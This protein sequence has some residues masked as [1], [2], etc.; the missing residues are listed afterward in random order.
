MKA[1]RFLKSVLILPMLTITPLDAGELFFVGEMTITSFSG[2]GCGPAEKTLYDVELAFRGAPPT[3]GYLRHS[4]NLVGELEKL[5]N[6]RW[7]VKLLF[8]DRT[9]PEILNAELHISAE[10]VRATFREQD[11]QDQKPHCYFREAELLAKR[12]ANGGTPEASWENFVREYQAMEHNMMANRAFHL[13]AHEVAIGFYERALELNPNHH[14]FMANLGVIHYR[15]GNVPDAVQWS[16]R[17]VLAAIP[18]KDYELIGQYNTIVREL[19]NSEP[20]WA[21]EKRQQASHFPPGFNPEAFS[22]ELLA[23]SEQLGAQAEKGRLKRVKSGSRESLEVIRKHLG[24]NHADYWDG[25]DTLGRAFEAAGDHDEAERYYQQALARRQ[26]GLG[27]NHPD[28]IDTMIH[29]ALLYKKQ[30]RHTAAHPFFEAIFAHRKRIYGESHPKALDAMV[31]FA[32]SLYQTEDLEAARSLWEQALELHI[33]VLGEKHPDTLVIYNNLANLYYVLGQ[34]DA[35]EPF[36]LKTLDLCSN[37]Y[38]ESHHE[39]LTSLNNLSFLYRAQGR[40]AKA[41]EILLRYFDISNEISDI[42]QKDRAL[43]MAAIQNMATLYAEMGEFEKAGAIALE[44]MR[45]RKELLG[46]EHPLTIV[47]MS[48]LAHLYDSL[49][50]F[51]KARPL[52]DKAMK[53]L[54]VVL[55][56]RKAFALTIMHNQVAHHWIQQQYDRAEP[57][58]RDIVEF[59]E[60][61]LGVEHP[62]YIAVLNNLGA[63]LQRQ[64]RL[65]ETEQVYKEAVRLENHFYDRILWGTSEI[66]RQGYLGGDSRFNSYYISILLRKGTPG[67]WSELFHYS[68]TRKGLLFR[69]ARRFR[70]LSRLQGHPDIERRVSQLR[71]FERRLSYLVMR[72]PWRGE[73]AEEEQQIPDLRERIDRL[74]AELAR[75]MQQQGYQIGNVDPEEILRGLEGDEILL[76]FLIFERHDLI[77]L[78]FIEETL[79]V[80]V[81]DPAGSPRIR[82]VDLGDVE[83][84]RREIAR[85]RREVASRADPTLALQGELYTRLW[86]PL[87]LYVGQKKTV[88]VVPDGPLHLLPIGALRDEDGKHLFSKHPLILLASVR[89]LIRED[90][91]VE[92]GAPAIFHSP[93][94]G[95]APEI[96]SPTSAGNPH[97]SLMFSP[98]P[99]TREEGR[100]LEELFLRE[101]WNTRIFFGNGADEETLSGLRSPRILHLATHGFFLEAPRTSRSGGHRGGE[102]IGLSDGLFSRKAGSSLDPMVFSGLALAGANRRD[103]GNSGGQGFDGILTGKEVLGLNLSGTELVVLSACD[104]GVGEIHQGEGVYGLHRAFQEAGAK[105]VLFTLWKVNDE[106]T[107][108][109][110]VRFYSLYLEGTSPHEAL[111]LTKEEFLESARWSHP[112][113]WAPFVLVGKD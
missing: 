51:D 3:I 63:N 21:E 72:D 16:K 37:I 29:L 73:A 30:E 9:V 98:L 19:Q 15:L 44:L 87:E 79:L 49:L 14:F 32:E 112:Y 33:D 12:V 8:H 113:Y 65:D 22:R 54:P 18:T 69:V 10:E 4:W 91:P 85:F 96:G 52:H 42:N 26:D 45:L 75:E 25:L 99:G 38:G 46:P 64:N 48:I 41:E 111:K 17:A 20:E 74:E 66:A 103:K 1:F 47:S 35:A 90:P 36:F 11:P 62:Q 97:T 106:A 83:P 23:M 56:Y 101:E 57:L 7:A 24:E 43:S 78:E 55:E 5:R 60:Q 2:Q 95:E 39:S 28:T 59:S 50:Q 71:D 34:F 108:A 77:N 70:E 40:L 76:D 105:R 89:D 31:L 110:M 67:A 94:F 81:V 104:T 68:L 61:L 109:F 82:A 27:V 100:K 80:L 107:Q 53:L 84:I 102:I 92:T 86:K 13:E 88:F 58:Q 93:E 6:S